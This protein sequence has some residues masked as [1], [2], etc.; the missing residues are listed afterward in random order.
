[1]ATVVEAAELQTAAPAKTYPIYVAGEWQES[2]DPL[3]VRSPFAGSL[4]GTTSQANRQQ[5]EEAIAG[6]VRAFEITRRLPTY[7]RV[8]LLKAMAAGLAARR[9]EVAQMISAE[10]G[11]P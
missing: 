6:A 3:E 11:K 4:V 8:A 7:E 1:M 2:G 9:D 10:S 5:L